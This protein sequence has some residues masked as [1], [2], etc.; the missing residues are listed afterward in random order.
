MLKNYIKIATRNLLK[1]EFYSLIAI[2]G[3]AVGITFTL[4]IGTY[5]W[6]ELQVNAKL[7]NADRQY[8]VQSKWKETNMGPD[9]TT[10]APMAK[11]LRD[12]Y[13]HLVANYYR[14]DA[15]TTVIS[16]GDKSFREEVHL[17]DSTL[18]TMYGFELL[19]GNARTALDAPSSMVISS[20]TAL[21]Y[22]GKLDVVGEAMTIASFSEEK[23]EYTVSGVLKKTSNNSVTNL[24]DPDIPVFLSARNMV[25]FD[26]GNLETWNRSNIVNYIE[27]QEGVQRED[28]IDPINQILASNAPENMKGNL[29]IYLTPLKEYYR[30]TN[31]GLVEKS[32]ITFVVVSFFILLM[33]I[34]NFVNIFIGNSTSRLKEI[35]VRKVLG[36]MKIQVINQFLTE[37]LI[38]AGISMLL[39]LLFYQMF[40]PYF[41][42]IVGKEMKSLLFSS[43][44]FIIVAIVLVMSIG[45]LAGLYPAF[46]LSKIQS[47]DAMKGKLKSVKENVLFRRSLIVSQFSIALFVIGSTYIIVQQVSYFFDKDLGY[48]KESILTVTVPRDWTAQGVLKMESIR[49]E[50]E[51]LPEIKKASLSYEIPNGNAGFSNGLYNMGEDSTNAIS[52]TILQTDEAYAETYQIP[53]AGGE[54]FSASKSESSSHKIVIN[55]AAALALGYGKP[56]LAVGGQVYF[57]GFDQI[58]TVEGVVENFH[59]GSM[60]RA[61]SPLVFTH[62]KNT[63][64]YRY[65]SFQIQPSNLAPSLALI[66]NKWKALLPETPFEFNFMDDSIKQLYKTEIQLQKASNVATILSLII[67]LLGVIGTV[68]MSVS[69]RTKELGIRKVLGASVGNIVFLFLHE[70]LLL[71][72]LAVI[73]SFP[74]VLYVMN[75]W[76]ENYA[77]SIGVDWIA[78]GSVGLIFGAIISLLVSLQSMRAAFANP[79]NAL[80][81]E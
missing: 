44:Y 58:F 24:L 70:F 1:H 18:L 81:N 59:F 10:L 3:L 68:S 33:S 37:S 21:K 71:L 5:V 28:L 63:N 9:F 67:V 11:T 13:P 43:L 29:E 39:S 12:N 73:I 76:L 75:M 50:M 40:L 16:T 22:F 47:I 6:Q 42:D 41:E 69:K 25:F 72:I 74:V 36:G 48:N 54:F 20:E 62:I 2:F 77:Y 30:E 80:K 7:R 51:N 15:I 26:R 60:H 49:N 55:E 64:Q 14:F 23:K 52:V 38:V 79:I 53:L 45:I 46:I 8:L 78:L 27:L 65:M 35:G 57:L 4:L 66:E 31:N 32:M 19:H 17:G 56:A 34:V 61:I